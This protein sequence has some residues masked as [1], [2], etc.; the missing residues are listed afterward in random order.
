MQQPNPLD[1]I[2]VVSPFSVGGTFLE[3]SINFLS[4]KTQY[5]NL[6]K[7]FIDLT[8][9][10]LEKFNAHGHE[11][12]HP[13]GFNETCEFVQQLDGKTSFVSLYSFPIT[14]L[15]ASKNLGLDIANITPDDWVQINRYRL[16]DFNQMLSW[17]ANKSA[18]IIYLSLD[19]DLSVYF[20]TEIRCF[21]ALLS[22]D[23][24]FESSEDLRKDKDLVFFKA[25]CNRWDELGLTN[26]WDIRERLALSTRPLEFT[27]F[28]PDLSVPHYWLGATELWG[29]GERKINDI[30]LWL[31][32]AVDPSKVE[33]WKSVYRSWQQI[34]ASSLEFQYQYKHIVEAIVNGWSYPIDLTFDQE[35]VI[36]HCLIYQ[37]NLNLKTWQLEK[38]PSNTLDL[39]KL[40]E[41][42]THPL[43]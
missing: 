10:P 13:G 32:L 5:F 1:V 24:K 12:N 31:G 2:C 14:P 23:N 16:N 3:W 20:N 37:H 33:P 41:I 38:F 17:L 34:I 30:M 43:G 11:K 25:S 28:K 19:E 27:E 29:N 9:N 4:G 21:D 15:N 40:L 42:N 26:T 6:H 18:K 7:G 8:R 22:K 36:Q 35:V 39:H